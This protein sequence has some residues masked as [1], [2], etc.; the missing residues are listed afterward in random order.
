MPTRNVQSCSC[1]QV[2]VK[3]G[4][5]DDAVLRLRRLTFRAANRRDRDDDSGEEA[6]RSS[7]SGLQGSAWTFPPMICSAYLIRRTAPR[8]FNRMLDLRFGI[9]SHLSELFNSSTTTAGRSKPLNYPLVGYQSVVR[10]FYFQVTTAQHQLT[11]A[12]GPT[13][14]AAS[15][16]PSNT[17]HDGGQSR[18]CQCRHGKAPA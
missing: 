1:L 8:S 16:Y 12:T 15:T 6:T 7:T 2:L 13:D 5:V 14:W 10:I 11:P 17:T 18:E 9:L 3:G 4:G